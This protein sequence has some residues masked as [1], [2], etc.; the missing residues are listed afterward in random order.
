MS[1]PQVQAYSAMR[2]S[3]LL[4]VFVLLLPL[5]TFAEVYDVSTT[6]ELRE[7]L[8]SAAEAGGDN[9]IRLAAGTYS[10]QDDGEGTFEY[11]SEYTTDLRLEQ[12]P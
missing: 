6:A 5:S 11:F 7:A 4:S 2:I 1:Q 12:L 8:A 3:R 10:T 9:T